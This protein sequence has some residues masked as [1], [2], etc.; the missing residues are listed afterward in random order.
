MTLCVYKGGGFRNGGMANKKIRTNDSETLFVTFTVYIYI[1]ICI[2]PNWILSAPIHYLQPYQF[3]GTLNFNLKPGLV[4]F[5]WKNRISAKKVV[6]AFIWWIPPGSQ[7]FPCISVKSKSSRSI[8]KLLS[9]TQIRQREGWRHNT[10]YSQVCLQWIL[11]EIKWKVWG[12]HGLGQ[13]Q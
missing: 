4:T 12:C 7:T 13:P 9:A 3:M 10:K 8:V 11:S 2:L 5:C 6:P 1:Y